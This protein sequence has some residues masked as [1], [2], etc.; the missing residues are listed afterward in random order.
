[1]TDSSDDLQ[2]SHY[3]DVE[4]FEGITRTGEL[5]CTGIRHLNDRS[6]WH[7]VHGAARRV[8]QEAYSAG[9]DNRLRRLEYISHMDMPPQ[10]EA[11]PLLQEFAAV[12]AYYVASF[13]AESDDLSQWRAYGPGRGVEMQFRS[14]D[15]RKLAQENFTLTRCDYD[16]NLLL[17]ELREHLQ[18]MITALSQTSGS[19]FQED[20]LP[21]S[22]LWKTGH[23]FWDAVVEM[24]PRHK[25][26]K[27]KAEQEWRLISKRRQGVA[28]INADT[29]VQHRVRGGRIAP[30]IRF[31]LMEKDD[32]DRRQCGALKH[33]I[34]GPGSDPSLDLVTALQLLQK[35]HFHQASVSASTIPYADPKR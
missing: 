32:Y 14:G 23:D 3:T 29:E 6:E 5:W 34:L 13:S 9:D 19:G 15:L 35:R 30:Y 20:G 18:I 28:A 17:N 12:G 21:T 4:G 26:P 25:H 7:Y 31:S 2:L 16:Q 27:F 10:K 11:Q 8:V 1:M 24:A 22:T 33:V